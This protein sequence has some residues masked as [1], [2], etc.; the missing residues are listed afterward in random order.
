MASFLETCY[1]GPSELVI[2][3]GFQEAKKHR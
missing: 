2:D 1:N 3:P